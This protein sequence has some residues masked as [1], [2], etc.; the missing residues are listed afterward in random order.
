MMKSVAA[1][2]LTR[3]SGPNAGASSDNRRSVNSNTDLVE[4]EQEGRHP[5]RQ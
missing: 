1:A 4:Q 2:T 5:F 3:K